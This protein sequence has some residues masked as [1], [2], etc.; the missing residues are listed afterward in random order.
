MRS[1][2]EEGLLRVEGLVRHFHGVAAIAGLTLIL[3][4]GESL[5]LAGG[6]GSGKT[7]L[8][9][10]ITGFARPE[11][12]R[13]WLGSQD[14]TGWPAHRIVHAGIGRTFQTPRVAP[15]LTVEQHL[16]AALLHRR[17]ARQ[18]ELR[19]TA[20]AVELMD[21]GG[22]RRRET[23]ALSA[24][25]VRRLEIARALITGT[26]LL[27]LDEPFAALGPDDLPA[28]ISA[29]R[30]LHTEGLT[31]LVAARGDG[32]LQALCDRIAVIEAGSV[33]RIPR[34]AGS[35]HA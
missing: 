11:R 12:G 1:P 8:I 25:Q 2:A 15:Q 9:D 13:V 20:R 5:G 22:V 29:L 16:Q 3:H 27:L 28:M 7:A 33:S 34:A 31:M 35:R 10:I 6:N 14:V 26:R 4:R 17:L 32:L 19:E 30:R 23:W 24:A 21:L 18:R